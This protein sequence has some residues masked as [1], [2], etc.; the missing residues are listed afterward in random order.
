MVQYPALLDGKKGAY[1]VVFPDIPGIGA[2]GST[3]NEA[4]ANA[5]EVLRDYAMEAH[6]DGEELAIPSPLCRLSKHR[7]ATPW[8]PCASPGHQSRA[9]GLARPECKFQ[10]YTGTEIFERPQSPRST[11]VG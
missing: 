3:I 9:S 7:Q 8:F 6:K 1:G 5:E 10:P 11:L 2:M 4:M